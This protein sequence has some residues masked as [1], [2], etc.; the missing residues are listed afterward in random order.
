MAQVLTNR[1]SACGGCQADHGCRSCLAT[2][3]K[4]VFTVQNPA[5]A[6][7]GDLVV[8]QQSADAFYTGAVLLYLLPVVTM[9]AG[10]LIGSQMAGTAAGDGTA[11]AII[12]GL[13]GLVGGFGLTLL[14]SRHRRFRNWIVPRIT[15]IHRRRENAIAPAPPPTAPVV[16]RPSCC[17]G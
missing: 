9:V 3:D 16:P 10:A 14:L 15:R 4:A 11:R 5:G 13:L 2:N 17:G 6:L 7:P 12:G 8:I 1:Q